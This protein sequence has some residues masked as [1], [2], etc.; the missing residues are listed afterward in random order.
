MIK[1]IITKI[2]SLHHSNPSK[3]HLKPALNPP[4]SIPPLPIILIQN[5]T[6][7]NPVLSLRA[8]HNLQPCQNVHHMPSDPGQPHRLPRQRADSRPLSLLLTLPPPAVAAG[9]PRVP[10]PPQHL[11]EPNKKHPQSKSSRLG[12]PVH[13][14]SFPSSSGQSQDP[15]RSRKCHNGAGVRRQVRSQRHPM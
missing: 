7:K 8:A 13:R 12:I 11:P 9:S 1:S 14:A 4:P 2:I 6:S 10:R 3:F 5:G 15:K